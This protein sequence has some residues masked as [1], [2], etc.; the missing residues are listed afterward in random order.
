LSLLAAIHRAADTV[1]AETL[2]VLQS[3][4]PDG[5]PAA[6][7]ALLQS[8]RGLLAHGIGRLTIHTIGRRLGVDTEDDV[9]TALERIA[10]RER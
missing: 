2:D 8:G 3:L 6:T 9:A 1:A 10:G 5:E 7:S 4:P